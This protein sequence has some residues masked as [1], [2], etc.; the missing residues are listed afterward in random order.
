MK[1]L[2]LIAALTLPSLSQAFALQCTVE[3][4]YHVNLG[5]TESDTDCRQ[6]NDEVKCTT[7]HF[8]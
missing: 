7:F 6:N 5:E 1:K 2:L 4:H 8:I 3:R